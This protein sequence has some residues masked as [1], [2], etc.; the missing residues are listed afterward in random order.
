[1]SSMQAA[2]IGYGLV[3]LLPR[4][5]A[6]SA[7]EPLV[8]SPFSSHGPM[9][10]Y[11]WNWFG[12]GRFTPQE[13]VVLQTTAVAMG[14]MPLTVG[15][16]G[17]VPALLQIRPGRDNGAMPIRLEGSDLLLWSAALSLFGVFFAVP[18]RKKVIVK[19]RLTFPSGTATAH[20]ISVLHR[21]K[22][23]D[24]DDGE[25]E[26]QG[27]TTGTLLR[28]SSPPESSTRRRHGTGSHRPDEQQRL[29]VDSL[30][31]HSQ[32]Y[33]TIDVA[34]ASEDDVLQ[35]DLGWK[36]LL[37]SFAVSISF[38][39][40]SALFPV[41]YAIPLFDVLPP[42]DLA[43]KWGW[44]F[45]PSLSYVGQ[46]IIMG[47]HTTTSMIAGAIFGWAFLS[48]LAHH[49]GWTE[50][51]PMNAETGSKGWILWISLA[52]MT[53][54][55]LIGLLVL[56]FTE[57]KVGNVRRILSPGKTRSPSRGFPETRRASAEISGGM[58]VE[59][60]EPPH[61]LP[62]ASAVI[63]GLI[64][65]SCFALFVMWYLFGVEG[66]EPYT[67]LL[68]ILLAFALSI[69]AVRSLG[70]TDLN[71]V[72]GLGKISQLIFAVLQPHNLTANLVAGALS[73]A[74]AMSSGEL[75]QDF[76]AGHLLR[77]SPR[78]QFYGQLIGSI[79]GVFVSSFA[80]QLYLKVYEIPS[81]SFPAPASQQWLNFA[82]LISDGTIPKGSKGW[83]IGCS[84]LF[85]ITGSVKAIVQAREL[86][87]SRQEKVHK[88]AR[89]NAEET[90]ADE[91]TKA[92][93][94]AWE[95]FAYYLPSGVAFAVGILN[96][97]NFS[98]ARF[99]GGLVS[100]WWTRRQQQ[101]Q[102]SGSASTSS[103]SSSKILI[104]ILASGFVLGEG[105]GSIVNL[106]GKSFGFLGSVTCAGCRGS[107]GGGC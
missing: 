70:Q 57:T 61:R 98:I 15:L 71:P 74:G 78:A 100:Y 18:L 1:M 56:V 49:S 76:K 101:R 77:A 33:R 28:T 29:L 31:S 64:L 25:E 52:I 32:N 105:A 10:R 41:L 53:S 30:P 69:L 21:V 13:N 68:A 60:D 97:P 104:I 37:A 27:K 34:D 47:L 95:R 40:S 87:R 55:S 7:Q 45:T 20:L 39:I 79:G 89:A 88:R 42:H 90:D 73:E 22:V 46:G 19:E 82:R 66:I 67:T 26:V 81:P 99:L 75:M 54:E 84:I 91:D 50:G 35:G 62:P 6:V 3:Q 11:F 106:F 44:Y 96:T 63:G 65:S 12:K 94:P 48:P 72:N 5:S 103:Q 107:C 17:I 8:A 38:T 36:T 59:V 86:E 80:Y 93:I 4:T 58:A 23:R 24:E 102:G 14:S 83:L 92:T 16:I 85:G 9:D 51:Q 43:A 2:L